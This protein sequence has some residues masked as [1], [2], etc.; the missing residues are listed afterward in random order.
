MA[1]RVW[2]HLFG[3]GIVRTVDDFGKSG[4]PPS[5]PLLLDFLAV[6]LVEH[7]WSIKSLIREIV[8]SRTW[9][10]SSTHDHF[11]HSHDPEN[12]Y[13]WRMS[14]RR[15]QAESIRDAMMAVS[16]NLT[17]LRP[18]GTFLASVGEGTIGRAV[19]EP[20]IRKIESNHRSVYLPRVR[21]VLPESLEL[22]DAPDGSLVTGNR[23]T[24]T[25]PLQALY[26]MNNPFV[27][28]QA[29]G[30]AKRISE[31]PNDERVQHAYLCLFGR[32]PTVAERQH[33]ETFAKNFRQLAIRE[34]YRANEIDDA[35]LSAYGHALLCTAEFSI[36]D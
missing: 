19:Y 5:H 30:L 24:T 20:Q 9:Q 32:L 11:N 17:K 15:L 14:P 8:L 22:F 6:R 28:K 23:E 1:N 13:L 29:D 18:T 31:Q 12:R 21:N 4:S 16:G 27:Q 25:N 34:G 35:W 7:N 10:L 36:L 26:L 3:R 2:H 33:A